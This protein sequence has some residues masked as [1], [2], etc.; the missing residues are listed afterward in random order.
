M[1][2]FVG[3]SFNMTL[4]DLLILEKTLKSKINLGLDIGSYDILA[5]FSREIKSRNFVFSLGIDFIKKFFSLKEKIKSQ[6]DIFNR[7]LTF[8]R[9]EI[10]HT[11]PKYITENKEK[12][13]EWII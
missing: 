11:F 9:I 1:H 5:E 3:Q 7:K 4:R 2:P 6:K 8:K 12:L 10:D 13:K